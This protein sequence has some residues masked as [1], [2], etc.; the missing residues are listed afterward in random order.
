[1]AKDLLNWEH[2]GF[3]VLRLLPWR[4]FVYVCVCVCDMPQNVV[5]IISRLHCKKVLQV[6]K[7][8]VNSMSLGKFLQRFK[9]EISRSGVKTVES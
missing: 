6:I 4:M 7:K 3:P 9:I 8:T 1:M 5:A 2:V